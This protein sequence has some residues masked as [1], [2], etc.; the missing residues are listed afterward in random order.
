MVVHQD[1]EKVEALTSIF[2]LGCCKVETENQYLVKDAAT[3]LVLLEA[4]ESSLWCLRNPCCCCDCTCWGCRFKFGSRRPFTLHLAK[5]HGDPVLLEITRT[6]SSYV[7]E[8]L[9]CCLQSVTVRNSGRLLGSV[10]QVVGC[11]FEV[12]DAE[13]EV[14]FYIGTGFAITD[15]EGRQVGE[16]TMSSS[17]VF[18]ELLTDGDRWLLSWSCYMSC[19]YNLSCS[20]TFF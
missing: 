7:S 9:P 4:T 2:S 16:V 6:C 10:R 11:K 3:D 17:N 20:D 19:S 15:T 1:L 13:A 14:Q 12:L 18:K 8:I 5:Q